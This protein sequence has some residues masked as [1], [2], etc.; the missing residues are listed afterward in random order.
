LRVGGRVFEPVQ[1][2]STMRLISARP[3]LSKILAEVPSITPT[4][5][6][7]G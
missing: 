2:D 4:M 3:E 5:V 1:G 7:R 6:Q